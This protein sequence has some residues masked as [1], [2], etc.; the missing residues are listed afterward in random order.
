MP[1]TD[2]DPIDLSTFLLLMVGPWILVSAALIVYCKD[3]LTWSTGNGNS[4]F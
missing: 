1:P 3:K 4:K 2:F